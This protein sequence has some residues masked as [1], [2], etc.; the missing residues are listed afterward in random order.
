[1]LNVAAVLTF[2][3]VIHVRY[4]HYDSAQVDVSRG[5]KK[6]KCAARGLHHGPNFFYMNNFYYSWKIKENIF[7]L[8][9]LR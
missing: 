9:I 7:I 8:G 6:K 3:K 2:I 4:T 1:M 5:S